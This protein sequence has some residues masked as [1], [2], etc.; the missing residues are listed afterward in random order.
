MSN[1]QNY[2]DQPDKILSEFYTLATKTIGISESALTCIFKNAWWPNLPTPSAI[3]LKQAANSIIPIDFKADVIIP[4]GQHYAAWLRGEKLTSPHAQ[5]LF[6][7]GQRWFSLLSLEHESEQVLIQARSEAENKERLLGFI[8]HELNSPLTAVIGFQEFLL[9]G[10][11]GSLRNEQANMLA[12][13]NRNARRLKNL[14]ADLLLLSRASSGRFSLHIEEVN[15]NKLI[16]TSI[17]N[18]RFLLEEKKLLLEV[19]VGDLPNFKGDGERLSQLLENLL[20]NAIKYTEAGKVELSAQIEGEEVKIQIRDTG[21][22]IPKDELKSLFDQFYRASN[23]DERGIHGTGLGLTICQ[24]IAKAHQGYIEAE[25]HLDGGSIFTLH[26]PSLP[27]S[28][29][30]SMENQGNTLVVS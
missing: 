18:V 3:I 28:R 13:A 8:A 30:R 29:A 17:E 10:G 19:H 7:L 22:G 1:H 2:S 25:S 9:S 4:F 11:A 23:A 15:L 26:L 6:Y 5:A 24:I 12:I 16:K 21:I 20:N 27:L 14:V